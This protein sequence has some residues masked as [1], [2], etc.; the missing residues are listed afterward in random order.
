MTAHTSLTGAKSSTAALRREAEDKDLQS[1]GNHR[2][3][4]ERAIELEI[5]RRHRGAIIP[6]PPRHEQR[7]GCERLALLLNRPRQ[8][9]DED[10]PGRCRWHGVRKHP[11]HA[12]D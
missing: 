1:E 8:R 9:F 12:L 7:G 10:L 5:R 3:K 6:S 11:P 2:E 4:H